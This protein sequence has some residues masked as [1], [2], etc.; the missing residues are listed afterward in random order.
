MK[1]SF[2]ELDSAGELPE[3]TRKVPDS[4]DNVPES[5]EKVP[6]SADNMPE[7]TEQCRIMSK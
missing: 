7:S 5:T 2:N 3:S 6:N 1:I 4:A